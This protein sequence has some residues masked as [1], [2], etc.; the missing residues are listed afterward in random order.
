[1]PTFNTE[2]GTGLGLIIAEGD[3]QLLDGVF[4]TRRNSFVSI[5]LKKA[6]QKSVSLAGLSSCLNKQ[7][8]NPSS[9]PVWRVSMSA[10]FTMNFRRP[11]LSSGRA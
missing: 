2:K 8:R 5:K 6:L 9:S 1:M 7:Y 10:Q 4:F 11:L 3:I